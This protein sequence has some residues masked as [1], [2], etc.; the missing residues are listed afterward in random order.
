MDKE[1]LLKIILSDIGEVETLVKSFQGHEEIPSA[2]IEL[3]EQKLAHILNEFALLRSIAANPDKTVAENKIVNKEEEL[4]SSS[5]V[6]PSVVQNQEDIKPDEPVIKVIQEKDVSEPVKEETN[7]VEQAPVE[8]K[9]I[10]KSPNSDSAP[11][12]QERKFKEEE[13]LISFEEMNKGEAENHA[14]T[15]GD[16]YVGETKSVNDL[17]ASSKESK[18]QKTLLGK[19]VNDLT[20]SLGIND[21]F[22][23]QR[24]LFEGNAD[25][26]LKTLQQ[27]NE[28]PDFSSAHS[29]ILANFR[30]DEEQGVTQAFYSY[31][32]RKYEYTR[33]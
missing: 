19:P 33:L 21:R 2:F 9:A 20:K 4:I 32:K 17:M 24:E 30:W 14:K 5:P 27:L 8:E 7:S 3:T 22:M 29:F 25:V 10:E 28:L 1:A 23:F 13:A 15:L 11:I 12:V 31:I 6:K 18:F 26:M 16:S